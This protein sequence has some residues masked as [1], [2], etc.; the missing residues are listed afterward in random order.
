MIGL[1]IYLLFSVMISSLQ[2]APPKIFLITDAEGVAGICRQSQTEPSN[3]ELQKLLTGEVNAAVRG[4]FQAGATEVIVWDAHDGSQTL[5]VESIEPRAQL[6]FGGLGP[7]MLLDRGFSAIAFIGQHARANRSNAVMAHSYSSMGIQR[8]LMNGKEVGEI[9]TRTALAGWFGVPVIML[10]GDKAAG[11]DLR[12]LVP[13]AEVAVVK[14]GF[15]YY[16][17]Q[18]LSASGAQ[19][20]IEKTARQAF[21]K[22]NQIHPFKV[23]GPVNFEVEFT[24]RSTLPPESILPARVHRVDARTLRYQGKDF[25]EAWTLWQSQ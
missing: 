13:E 1:R 19:D 20:L 15:G 16:S 3:P 8:I 10:S 4:F 22:I 14:E 11:E 6:I 18:S 5:S 12:A 21:A 24:T 2:A 17:C 25:F 9:E 23:E 7:K